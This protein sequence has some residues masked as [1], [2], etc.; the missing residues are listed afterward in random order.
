MKMIENKNINKFINIIFYIYYIYLSHLIWYIL[1]S[2]LIDKTQIID[3]LI[4]NLINS[5][6]NNLISWIFIS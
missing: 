1:Q 3:N 5:L 2:F 6:I 4:D